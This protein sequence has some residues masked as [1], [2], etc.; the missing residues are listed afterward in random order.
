MDLSNARILDIVV[1]DDPILRSTSTEIGEID[2]AT[3]DLARDMLATMYDAS[4]IGLAAVQVG[5]PVRM[6][7]FDVAR[8][9]GPRR[10]EVM[11]DPVIEW[12]KKLRIEME[13]G[14]LSIPGRRVMVS[15]PSDIRVSYTQLDGTRRTRDLGGMHARVVQHEIDH[16]NGVLIDRHAL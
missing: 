12:S 14:C 1:V 11:I 13:E 10:P 5:R 3:R 4:G 7:V 9:D 8:K 16:L 15:R 6:I 2:D